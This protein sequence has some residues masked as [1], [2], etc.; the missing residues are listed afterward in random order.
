VTE[1]L[2]R[3]RTSP[4]VKIGPRTSKERIKERKGDKVVSELFGHFNPWKA[5][6]TLR[7][8]M[9]DIFNIK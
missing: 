9:Q 6:H 5:N 7:F 8:L 1:Y 2:G 3:P 4:R